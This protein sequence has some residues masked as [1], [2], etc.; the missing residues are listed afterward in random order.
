MSNSDIH[1][2]DYNNGDTAINEASELREPTIVG[3]EV[4]DLSGTREKDNEGNVIIVSVEQNLM[5][6]EDVSKSEEVVPKSTEN[7]NGSNKFSI[8]I[9]KSGTAKCK[10]CRKLI[11]KGTFRIGK[12]VPFKVGHINQFFH[13]D[14]AFDSFLEARLETNVIRDLNEINGIELVPVEVK[15]RI[16]TLINDTV[17]KITRPLGKPKMKINESVVLQTTSKSRK[18]SLKSLSLPS[19]KV[20]FTNADQLSPSKMVELRKQVEK[21]KPLIIAVSEVKQK[22]PNDVSVMDY[23][24]HGY[25][26]HP[27]NLD[28]EV[29]R[30][31]AVYTKDALEKSVNQVDL[32]LRFD[33]VCLL[34]V[35]LRGGDV[36]LFGCV[37]RSPTASDNSKDNNENLN[38][39]LK[40]IANR[41]YS[42]RCIVGDF[43]YKHINWA[44]WT[45]P[46][47]E[48]SAEA[49]FIE[50]VR[51]SFLYQ[52]VEKSTR[53]RGNDDPSLLDLVLTDES[54]QVSEIT[55]HAPLGKS[56]HSIISFDFNCYLDFSKPKE[57]FCFHKGDY[58]G[59]R[60][61][62]KNSSYIQDYMTI[63]KDAT[64]EDKW[65]ALKSIFTELRDEFVPKQKISGKPSWKDKGSF[66]INPETR[67]AIK[68][69]NKNY[70]KWMS[71]TNCERDA[72]RLAYIKARNRSKTLLRKSKRSFEKN[73]ASQ[74]KH[75]PKAFWNHT[76]RKLKTKCGVAPLLSNLKDKNSLKYNDEEKANILQ[77]QFSSVFIKEPDGAIPTIS[78]RTDSYITNLHVTEEMVLTELST[79]NPNKSCGPENIHPRMLLEL[80]D[81]M[82]APVALLFN[83]TI[84]H[85]IIPKDWKLGYISPI[86]KKGSKNVAENYRPISLTS[87]LC[88]IIER[89]V[90]GVVLKHLQNNGLLSKRQFGFINGRSTTTQLL[91][92]LDKCISTIVEGGVIDTI[93]LDFAKAFDTVAHRRL[94][95]K[96]HAYG[97]KGKIFVWIKEFLCGRTQIVKVNGA[98]SIPTNVLSGIPQGTVLGPLLFVIYINDILEEVDSDGLLFADDTKIFRAIT[99]KE[100]A[101]NLQS[102]LKN[103]E[104][105]SSKWLMRFHPDKCHVLTLGK[106]ENIRYT[107]RY[108][109]NNEELEHVFEEKDLGV[110]IDSELSFT[111]HISSKVRVANGIVGLIRR[112]FSYLDCNSFKKMYTAFVRPHLEYAQAVWAPHS[113]KYVNMLENVQIRATKLVDGLGNIEYSQRLR[114]LNLPTL[115]FRR[116][117]GDMIEVYKHFRKYDQN[118]ISSSFLPK[119]RASRKH[120]FQLH[121]HRARDGIRGAQT[122]SFYFRSARTWNNL[123]KSVVNAENI[124]VFKNR[125]DEV[126]KDHHMKFDQ[127]SPIASD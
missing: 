40:S 55:H 13:V 105:W 103:L 76:R 52:H 85:G 3:D 95:G 89:F 125:L 79:L 1:E 72:A 7:I 71:A 87:V 38:Q 29:G 46:H 14:C 82:A 122:N 118:T 109:I 113:Q 30:G 23:D 36:L 102:D 56:D 99:S 123:P 11:T 73:I 57:T 75:N 19:L 117:R 2:F 116:M 100:D 51:D 28:N 120:E 41:K 78:N 17:A 22:N 9:S 58:E 66:P 115:A 112:S 25:T 68:T 47:G 80:A 34:E 67:E 107:Q 101:L 88:K 54:M 126:W 108:M 60:N 91:Y 84:E 61:R 32:D 97:I 45:T 121:E 35:R 94:L 37:Y 106:F 20:M 21:E 93:Y 111:E 96:L 49:K 83:M 27:V 81:I 43:N 12:L 114:Q 44:T 127:T 4:I 92:Y 70:K 69:K 124:N 119:Q 104:E 74:S 42:H 63:N 18:A 5:S 8:D 26:L 53:R 64:V 50:S 6:N 77:D 10:K 98:Q 110:I 90:R 15:S 62:I 59:M 39:L 65:V 33:E 31:I 86:H 16:C 48:T 24:I